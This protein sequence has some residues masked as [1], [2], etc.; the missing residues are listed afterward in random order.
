MRKAIEEDLGNWSGSLRDLFK[1]SSLE[2]RHV[3]DIQKTGTHNEL[4]VRTP[5][6]SLQLVYY[7]MYILHTLYIVLYGKMDL[8]CMYD[9]V[10]WLASADFIAAGYHAMVCAEVS[11]NPMVRAEIS[12]L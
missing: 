10:E 11:F 6:K 1:D 9:D 2:T 8:K 3:F 4:G 5:V 7:G 12:K